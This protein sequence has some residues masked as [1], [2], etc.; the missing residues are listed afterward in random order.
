MD[1]TTWKKCYVDPIAEQV[2]LAMGWFDSL[3]NSD[4]ARPFAEPGMIWMSATEAGDYVGVTSKT[5]NNW[6]EKVKLP[7]NDQVGTLYLFEKS[8]LDAHKQA[9]ASQK[10]R[11]ATSN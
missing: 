9:K 8:I 3:L 7:F 1:L 6:I 4:N 11:T 2:Q 5:I 10:R